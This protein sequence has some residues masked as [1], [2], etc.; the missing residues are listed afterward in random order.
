[1]FLSPWSGNHYIHRFT[2]IKNICK[3]TG[4]PHYTYHCIRHF[5]ASYLYDKKEGEPAGDLQTSTPQELADHGN[6]FAVHRQ[7]VPR[8]HAAVGRE[9]F[10]KYNPKPLSNPSPSLPQ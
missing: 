4:V 10:E 3:W 1:V 6:L 7:E 5:V 8:N 9:K 2:L